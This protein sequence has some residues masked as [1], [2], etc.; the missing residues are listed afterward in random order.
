MASLVFLALTGVVGFLLGYLVKQLLLPGG[1]PPSSSR[2][3]SR[4]PEVVLTKICEHLLRDEDVKGARTSLASCC[5][6]SKH[7]LD[8]A[9]PVLQQHREHHLT[10]VLSTSYHE[11]DGKM[12][13]E[14]HSLDLKSSALVENAA[15]APKVCS[16]EFK[17]SSKLPMTFG[18]WEPSPYSSLGLLFD[19]IE[20]PLAVHVSGKLCG[21]SVA[22]DVEKLFPLYD[23]LS[24]PRSS[25]THL[26]LSK[27]HADD[28]LGLR[29]FPQLRSLSLGAY[30]HNDVLFTAFQS[31][32][33]LPITAL[34]LPKPTSDHL[35]AVQLFAVFSSSLTRVTLALSPH[36]STYTFNLTPLAVLDCVTFLVQPQKSTGRV[37]S[38]LIE[39]ALHN[40]GP[41]ILDST[42]RV[43]LKLHPDSK[44]PV[45]SWRHYLGREFGRKILKNEKITR[46]RSID[47]TELGYEFDVKA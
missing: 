38:A 36:D 39:W 30:T 6:V 23:I 40:Y 8:L 19:R 37:H 3:R 21:L 24:E 2:T 47:M 1:P 18:S 29:H 35:S 46:V 11:G 14:H 44:Q 22:R 28:L 43:T 17:T 26:T 27:L 45:K 12:V 10:L 16:I 34:A 20:G 41:S 13:V 15:T 9:R 25:I 7:L 33:L 31:A 4:L 42:F 32:G 5:L